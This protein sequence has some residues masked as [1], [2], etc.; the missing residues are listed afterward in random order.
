M[1]A[2]FSS[3]GALAVALIFYAHRDHVQTQARRLSLIRERLAYLLWS[4]G[5][6]S[7]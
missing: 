3:L 1:T 2:L 5:E 6:Q 7:S 4:A